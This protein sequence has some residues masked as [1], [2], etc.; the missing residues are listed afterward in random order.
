MYFHLVGNDRTDMKK[1]E[2]NHSCVPLST[3]KAKIKGGGLTLKRFEKECISYRSK[4]KT[5]KE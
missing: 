4:K 5:E 1:E 2:N 3:A